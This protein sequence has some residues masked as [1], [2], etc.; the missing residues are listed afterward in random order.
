MRITRIH[1]IAVLTFVALTALALPLA[2]APQVAVYRNWDNVQVNRLDQID[3]GATESN[4]PNSRLFR[5]ENH[6]NATLNVSVS[7]TQPQSFAFSIIEF[8]AATVAPGGSTT[9]RVRELY[10]SEGRWFGYVNVNTNDPVTPLFQFTVFGDVHG[11]Y[12]SVL[13]NSTF[14]AQPN[15]SSFDFGTIAA[16]T[17][18]SR[19][20]IINNSGTRTLTITNNISLV[21]GT[22]FV[23]IET[24]PSSIGANGGQGLFR[25]RFAPTS[26]GTAYSGT[27]SI[28]SNDTN[29]SPYVINITGHSN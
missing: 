6:G 14:T 18:T 3:Y 1:F 21:S 5:I 11:P 20:W 16:G 9:F 10:S 26:P 15:G 22:G 29:Q 19:A 2:A 23:Q 4:V 13:Q 28:Q 27:I 8:P 24:P 12:I 25:V 7:L 17:V